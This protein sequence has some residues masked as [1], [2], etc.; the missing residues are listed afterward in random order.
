MPLK[1][2]VPNCN[3]NYKSSGEKV[4]IYKFPKDENEK[5]KWSKVIPRAKQV[6][7]AYTALCRKHW[8]EDCTMVSVHGKNRPAEPPSIFLNIPITC[9][10]SP[11]SKICKTER[12]S[13][14]TRNVLP[15]ELAEFKRLDMLTF[16]E[17]PKKMF[18]EKSLIVYKNNSNLIIQSVEFF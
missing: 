8:P 4:S 17:I 13:A 18:H 2:C 6:V 15:D 10:A 12:A 14:T 16:E 1:C 9:F 11:P 3:S 5:Q 7:T